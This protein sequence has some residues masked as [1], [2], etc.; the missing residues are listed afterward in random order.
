MP[1]TSPI[2][3]CR[4]GTAA[5]T[6][7][8]LAGCISEKTLPT[9]ADDGGTAIMLA[10]TGKLR[11][12]GDCVRLDRG[13]V[14]YLVLWSHGARVDYGSRPPIVLDGRGGSAR[15]GDSVAL[16]GGPRNPAPVT[17]RKTAGIISRCGG[18]VFRAYGFT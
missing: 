13:D 5:A 18:P 14:S 3:T 12:D 1:S 2:W 15:I 11:L 7:L 16:E 9:A 6:L 8:L 10:M 17:S 4:R